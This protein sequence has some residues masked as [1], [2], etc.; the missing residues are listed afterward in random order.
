MD[1]QTKIHVFKTNLETEDGIRAVSDTL[2]QHPGII[3][4][5]VDHWDV[6]NVLRVETDHS[7]SPVSIIEMIRN[8]GFICDEL[9]D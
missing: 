7:F 9:P 3:C 2:N 1:N 5:N 6:D 4:W 8:E